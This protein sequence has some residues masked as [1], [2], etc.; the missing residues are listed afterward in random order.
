MGHRISQ[1]KNLGVFFYFLKNIAV[2]D[3]RYCEFMLSFPSL[4]R[5]RLAMVKSLSALSKGHWLPLVTYL[6]KS[7]RFFTLRWDLTYLHSHVTSHNQSTFSRK[8]EREH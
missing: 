1:L 3:M 5:A 4:F 2:L 6:P 7:E 8:E